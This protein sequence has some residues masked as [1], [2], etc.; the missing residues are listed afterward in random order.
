MRSI[1]LRTSLVLLL[2][3]A[4]VLTFLVVGTSILMVRLP[5]VEQRSRTLAQ[6]AAENVQRL[7]DR[8]MEGVEGQLQPLAVL[9]V[10]GDAASLQAYLDALVAEGSVFDAVSLLDEEGKVLATGHAGGSDK[11][12]RKNLE[13]MDFAGNSLFQALQAQR[14][15]SPQSRQPV[16]SDRY[17]SVLSGQIIVG[18]ALHAGRRTVVGEMPP[19]RLL[20][21]I[22]GVQ[23]SDEGAVVV[24][25]RRGRGL[26]ATNPGFQRPFHDYSDS[27]TFKAALK[28]EALPNYEDIN[29]QRFLV[30]GTRTEKL[31][32]VIASGVPAGMSNYSYRATLLLVLG[33][34]AGAMLISLALAPL[35]AARMSQPFRLLAERAHRIA[36][37]DFSRADAGV[38]LIREFGLLSQDLD[39]MADAI[40]KREAAMQRGEQR[41]KATLES[42]PAV[43]IQW[44]DIEGRVL[45]WNQASTELYGFNAQEAMSAR[46]GDQP[47]MFGDVA[48]VEG[49]L[50]ALRDIERTGLAVGPVE[51][52]LRHKDG[53]SIHVLAST[54]SIPGE[55]DQPV[56]VCM[57]IDI[58]QRKQA[59]E[60]LRN[61]ELKLE[62]IFNASPAPMSVSDMRRGYRIV[63][64]NRSWEQLFHRTREQV[65]GL[66]GADIDLWANDAER[67][68]FLEILER[69]GGVQDFEARCVDSRGR[70]ILCQISALITE[71]GSERLLLM[72]TVDITDRRRIELEI[73][74]LN[75]EL[76]QRVEQ[77]TEELRL[78]NLKL[79]ETIDTLTFAQAQLVEAEKLA[80]LGNLVAGVAHELNTPIGNGLMAV[81][82]LDERLGDFRRI[83]KEGLTYSD[84]QRFTEAVEMAC[85]ISM[86]NLQRAATLVSSFKQVAVDQTSSQRRRFELLEVV[87]EV[88]LTLQPT[89]RKTPWRVEVRV[90]QG[91]ALD[92]YPGA[93]GQVLTNLIANA[94]AHAFDDRASGTITITGAA[95]SDTEILFSIGDD[96]QGIPEALQKKIFEPFFTTKMGQGGTGLGLHIVFNAV[97]RVLGGQISLRSTLHQGS[98]FEVRIPRVAPSTEVPE[99][100]AYSH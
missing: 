76:E 70:S 88:L 54:F 62:T 72:M 34:F 74:Q 97:T 91:L 22:S 59:E 92:S 36:R 20:R 24:I 99:P 13:G 45:Y 19:E 8:F 40:L 87:D 2:A 55:T 82:T 27:S 32:W 35:W 57:D 21:L 61:N 31:G 29:G 47:L 90:P 94:V 43:A 73:N 15:D 85:S 64:V 52:E 66:N 80:A 100:R 75:V 81:S 39:G 7:L 68:K 98:V 11:R 96:G 95:V 93:L 83:V 46:L 25:D 3:A 56:F 18:V 30:G 37:G 60:A 16:W 86:R 33:G 10:R 1:S 9:A 5:Q 38:G 69:Q 17:L 50:A 26:A 78:A 53:H 12:F 41:M 42:T 89:L 58:T 84:L 44:F 79:T 28:G 49:F 6:L 4:T 14:R 65:L 48:G 23:P 71:I 77:R 67:Q 63:T 51:Y